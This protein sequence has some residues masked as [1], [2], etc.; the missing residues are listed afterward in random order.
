MRSK[1]R[2][3]SL[4]CV[5]MA[6]CLVI[7]MSLIAVTA[8]EHDIM[9]K[10]NG[11]IATLSSTAQRLQKGA[12]DMKYIVVN[13]QRLALNSMLMRDQNLLLRAPAESKKFYDLIEEMKDLLD[14]KDQGITNQLEQL[15]KDYRNFLFKVIGVAAQY[16]ERIDTHES[17]LVEVN[18]WAEEFIKHLNN[19][20][21]KIS[22]VSKTKTNRVALYSNKIHIILLGSLAAIFT[23]FIFLSFL[24]EWKLFSPL[25]R[26]MAFV[27]EISGNETSLSKRFNSKHYDEIGELGRSLDFM[28]DRLNQTTVSRDLLQE[29]VEERRRA[30]EALTDIKERLEEEVAL[31]TKKLQFSYDELKKEIADRKKTELEKG[32]L[33]AQLCQ[34]QKMDALGALA[35][36]VAHDFNN[37]LA[38]VIGYAEL[39]LADLTDKPALE[40][41]LAEI[42]QSGE[43]GAAMVRQL[44]TFS[45]QKVSKPSL[46][47]V[48]EIINRMLNLLHRLIGENIKLEVEDNGEPGCIKADPSQ[49][50]Q[51][52]MNL[53]VNARDAMPKGGTITIQTRNIE[54]FDGALTRS[55]NIPAGPYVCI[56]VSDTGE[57][58]DASTLQ[59]MFEPFFTTKIM[60]KGTG[61][62]LSTTYGIVHNSHGTIH[63]DSKVGEGTKVCV[64][65]PQASFH[66]METGDYPL[67]EREALFK[68]RSGGSIVLVEDEL[69]VLDSTKYMLQRMGY[70]VCAF[71]DPL[72]A[73]EEFNRRP[74]EFDLL[75]SD[76]VMPDCDGPEL[77]GKIL[78][79][80]PD[81]NVIFM[82]GYAEHHI[83]EAFM[84]HQNTAFIQKPF[85]FNQLNHHV[86]QILATIH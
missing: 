77:F 69:N 28:L 42:I 7:S 86:N 14:D 51:V 32:Q 49:L 72:Q 60:G 76:V 5:L 20:T 59:R 37:I 2:N 58:M 9:E 62:G 10:V 15:K 19:I 85:T 81:L 29:E 74:G 73:E 66:A 54:L 56:T 8:I 11:E 38:V 23:I 45:R 33:Q 63:V 31:R 40:K 67:T 30:E 12:G 68:E 13:I 36:G 48:N 46:I 70:N 39:S 26:L 80:R 64:Y 44:L 43:R 17:V 79:N 18:L 22:L 35:G 25:N 50:E 71:S 65:L 3:A 41:R 75:I 78:P 83:P 6:V 21:D 4:K 1:L 24:V 84:R 61:L 34:V 55:A 82:S 57:G 53:V 27:R 16:V 47:I 52:V